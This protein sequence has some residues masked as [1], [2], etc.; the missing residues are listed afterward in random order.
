MHSGEHQLLKFKSK[1]GTRKNLWKPGLRLLNNS[2]I[3]I[4]FVNIRILCGYPLQN[5]NY[6][7]V[8][9]K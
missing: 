7:E 1:T 9:T 2:R 4:I 8:Q 6:V 5:E 3:S